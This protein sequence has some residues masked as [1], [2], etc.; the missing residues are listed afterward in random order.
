[1]ERGIETYADALYALGFHPHARPTQD[2][3]KARFRMLAQIYHPDAMLGDTDR[4]SQLND[5]IAFLRQRVA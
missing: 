4:M 1:M 2:D 3:I 5:A